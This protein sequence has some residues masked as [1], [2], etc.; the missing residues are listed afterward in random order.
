[1]F[2]EAGGA[3]NEP[4]ERNALTN[5]GLE[6]VK[7]VRGWAVA[8]S[9]AGSSGTGLARNGFTSVGGVEAVGEDRNMGSIWSSL[10]DGGGEAGWGE[11]L[12][13]SLNAPRGELRG[14]T[15]KGSCKPW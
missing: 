1:M 6:A 12:S 11:G 3:T 5:C 14:S 4:P 8:D 7:L 2:A 10:T 15:S 9:I 13:S